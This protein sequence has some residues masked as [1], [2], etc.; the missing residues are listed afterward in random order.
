MTTYKC[1]ASVY[2]LRQAR[3][4]ETYQRNDMAR[5]SRR[6]Q[7][8]TIAPWLARSRDR[9]V[10]S[11]TTSLQNSTLLVSVHQL[12]KQKHHWTELFLTVPFVAVLVKSSQAPETE[13]VMLVSGLVDTTTMAAVD[14]R[15]PV[16]IPD[17]PH[18]NYYDWVLVRTDKRSRR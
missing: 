3:I 2:G 10:E 13:V 8:E 14:H 6:D 5:D 17:T 4:H 11:E 9:G 12:L 7:D 16:S 15:V 18:W 1:V